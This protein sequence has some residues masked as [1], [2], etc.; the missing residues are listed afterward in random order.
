M[1]KFIEFLVTVL[2]VVGL[3]MFFILPGWYAAGAIVFGISIW[4]TIRKKIKKKK[5]TKC[6]KCK[7]KYDYDRDV[8]WR[9]I[10]S[11]T[12]D[13]GNKLKSFYKFDIT[14]ECSECGRKTRYNKTVEGPSVNEKFEVDATNPEY[15]LQE[16]FGE[17]PALGCGVTFMTLVLAIG[18]AIGG[19]V[20]G[21]YC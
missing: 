7:L 20:L 8:S 11:W 17:E 12:K 5:E 6:T 2:L 19:L 4:D 15:I 18:L 1:R 13:C 14:C 21:G 16:H 9:L 3:A 10:K